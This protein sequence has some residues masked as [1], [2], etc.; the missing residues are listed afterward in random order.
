MEEQLLQAISTVGFPIVMSVYLI[1]KLDKTMQ[2]L[3]EAVNALV[4]VN[5][6]KKESSQ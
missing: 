6:T 1:T 3:T 2:K 5:G 4:I